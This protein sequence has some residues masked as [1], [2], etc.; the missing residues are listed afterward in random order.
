MPKKTLQLFKPFQNRHLWR[1]SA[2]SLSVCEVL[3]VCFPCPK[4]CPETQSLRVLVWC[5]R[6]CT[7][8]TVKGG[9]TKTTDQFHWL[10]VRQ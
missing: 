1:V 5:L 6:R 10:G 4:A 7:G 9:L 2:K 3:V 8:T